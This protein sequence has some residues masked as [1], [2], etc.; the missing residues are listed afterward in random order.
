M[1]D[2]NM[3][4]FLD[5]LC[6]SIQ[7]TENIKLKEDGQVTYTE[8][9]PQDADVYTEPRNFNEAWNNQDEYQ[10]TKWRQAIKQMEKMSVYKKIN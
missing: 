9:N 5:D 6:L 7:T 4:E 10:R 1:I 2:Q 8:A 3:P